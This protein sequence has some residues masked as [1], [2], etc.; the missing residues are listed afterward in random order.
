MCQEKRKKKENEKIQKKSKL[1]K[2][3]KSKKCGENK[4]YFKKLGEIHLGI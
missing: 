2:I 4:V 3:E 1:T